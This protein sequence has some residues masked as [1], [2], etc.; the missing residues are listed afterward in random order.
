MPFF[1]TIYYLWIFTIMSLG[2][3][4]ILQPNG[5]ILLRDYAR[6]D[7]A[8]VNSPFQCSVSLLHFALFI[9]AKAIFSIFFNIITFG[10]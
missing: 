2:G 9:Y 6:G 5:H 4:L 7:S 3:Y 10:I 1:P 8:Q